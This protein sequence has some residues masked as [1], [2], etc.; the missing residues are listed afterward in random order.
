MRV[1]VLGGTGHFGGRICRRLSQCSDIDLIA[2]GHADLDM[3]SPEFCASLRNLRPD[4][5]IHTAGPF[6]HQDYA[7]A[8]ACIE[9]GCHYVDLADGR[10]FVLGFSAL[11][12]E[13]KAAGVTLISGASTLP[14]VSS[15]VVEQARPRFADIVSVETS[16]APAHQTPRGLA[17][18][19][20]VLG[21]CGKSF[22]SLRNG[23]WK[24]IH[25]WQDLRVQ[26]YPKLG[27]RLSAACDVPDLELMPAKI[28]GLQ[29]ASFHAALD[30]WWEQISLWL[31]AWLSRI[32]M[33][34][35]WTR[36]AKSISAISDRTRGLGSKCG[37]MRLRISGVDDDGRKLRVD[38]FVLATNNH[39][40]EIPCTPSIVVTKK[41]LRGDI[42]RRGAFA[43]WNLFTID[44]L[45]A[46]MT[47]FDI[48]L[49]EEEG[50]G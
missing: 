8:R 35:D 20:S 25:G 50:V 45:L 31:M 36:F 10:D 42:V 9:S 41:L 2:P 7:V 16:I 4:V 40:P 44:E 30:A 17:T 43:C 18:M 32:G 38:W 6:Q 12:A 23:S 28:S 39:G 14:G 37:G 47:E 29:T 13:A 5:L 11:D 48:S 21:Y 1:V 24:T 19:S 15:S 27:S 3:R 26:R 33:V 22:T 49:H 34:R 46:E